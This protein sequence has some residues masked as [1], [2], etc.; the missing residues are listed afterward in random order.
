[1][2]S[3]HIPLDG[4]FPYLTTGSPLM[5]NQEAL[6]HLVAAVF[7]TAIGGNRAYALST[8]L[9]L[10]VWPLS[11][12]LG[13]RLLGWRP[14]SAL[15]AAIVAPLVAAVT[16]YGYEFGSY[17][18]AGLGLWTQ[19]WGMVLL[20]P[21]L[22]LTWRAVRERRLVVPAA[23]AVA[24]TLAC[25]LIAGYF[26]I[27]ALVVWILASR[28]AGVARVT[29]RAAALGG[30]ALAASS[31]MLIPRLQAGRWAIDDGFTTA[32][33]WRNSFGLP[34]EMAWLFTGKL[35]DAGANGTRIPVVTVLV[36]LGVV[37]CVVRFRQDARARALL[38]LWL[39]SIFLFAGPATFGFVLNHIPGSHELLFHRYIIAV[40]LTGVLLAGVGGGWLWGVVRTTVRR[41]KLKPVV[42]SAIAAAI[43]VIVLAPAWAE[44]AAYGS[45]SGS[46]I[47]SQQDAQSAGGQ[48]LADAI[49]VVNELRDGRVYSGLPTN[50]GRANEVGYEPAYVYFLNHDTDAI[51]FTLRPVRNMLAGV[52]PYINEAVMGQLEAFGIRYLLLP[53]NS[54]PSVPARRIFTGRDDALWSVSTTGYMAVVDTVEPIA[55]GRASAAPIVRWLSSNDASRRLYPTMAFE[56]AE[57]AAATSS[58]LSPPRGSPGSVTSAQYDP[59]DG[60]FRANVD[61]ARTAAVVL[62][63]A[64]TSRWRVAVDGRLADA[65]IVAPGYPA[66]T[67]AA[68]TH[69]VEFSYIPSSGYVWYLLVTIAAL[70][71]LYVLFGRPRATEALSRPAS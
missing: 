53:T 42:A 17:T 68:G 59:S 54:V 69:T 31:W 26:A 64:Y 4:W 25:H 22:G 65:Y 19:A 43:A 36:L 62:K 14:N 44:R 12:Y 16:G 70:A 35:Y 48:S 28:P 60:V 47:V 40:H 23:I 9:L 33:F 55:V 63:S 13:A 11:V 56:G 32:A 29:G 24:L 41:A 2:S 58:V 39:L 51:G 27:L 66:V 5:Q 34:R 49:D 10:A 21:T 3:G 20:P 57:A 18:F 50:W 61:A 7:G 1:L 45:K 6:P 67:V 71:A 46:L 37:V 38:G 8:Y 52:E 30:G 15:A